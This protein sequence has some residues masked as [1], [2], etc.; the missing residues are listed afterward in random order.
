MFN[1]QFSNFF[2]RLGKAYKDV[3]QGGLGDT[4]TAE[5]TPILLG[6]EELKEVLKIVINIQ[7]RV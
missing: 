5:A 2:L 3:V 6:L 1:I 4:V 7:L